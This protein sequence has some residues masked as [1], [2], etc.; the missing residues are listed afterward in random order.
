MLMYK[1]FVFCLLFF[2]VIFFRGISQNYVPNGSLEVTTNCDYTGNSNIH[3]AIPWYNPIINGIA[4]P[5]LFN[6]CDSL[7]PFPQGNIMGVPYNWIGYQFP[8]TGNNMGG[9]QVYHSLNDIKEY[10]SIP[11]AD[12]LEQGVVYNCRYWVSLADNYYTWFP[13]SYAKCA[14]NELSFLISD[15]LVFDTA[16]N[17]LNLN[18]NIID[19]TQLFSDTA[20][21][22]AVEG[23]FTAIGNETCLT[24][25]NF[26]PNA[27]LS[28]TLI[29]PNPAFP[30]SWCNSHYYFDDVAIWQADT[31]PPSANTGKD[32]L[33]CYGDSIMLG[34]HSYT[35]Y[36]YKWWPSNGLSCE[37]CGQP[38]AKPLQTTTYILESTDFIYSKTYDTITVYMDKCGANAGFNRTICTESSV[39]LGDTLNYNYVCYWT[40]STY[41]N[42]DSVPM[43]VANPTNDITYF[44]YIYDSLGVLIKMDSVSFKT[45]DCYTAAAGIDTSVCVGDSIVIGTHNHSSSS[46]SWHPTSWL[47][48]PNSGFTI[49]FPYDTITYTLTV[50]DTLGNISVDSIT[51]YALN[52]DTI[53]VN[54]YFGESDLIKIWPNPAQDHIFIESKKNYRNAVFEIIDI[55]GQLLLREDIQLCSIQS[56][57][58]NYLSPGIYYYR[59]L[60]SNKL[61]KSNNLLVR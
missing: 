4:T 52:C 14:I 11:L 23:Q 13:N 22:M 47:N 53:G 36:Q 56:V 42:S 34:S 46:Y 25:G 51:I 27:L 18:A 31:I 41:L 2:L 55:N 57:N 40:P 45:V 20:N 32:T 16:V 44:L 60:I 59:I 5:D 37:D 33:I 61:L 30:S 21:W 24:I 9:F 38:I 43:P 10:A 12:T 6:S 58:I 49:I 39:Q 48:D 50:V 15:T 17:F 35:D 29:V 3:Y 19:S 7:I 8:R 28:N 54:E 26:T 1:R